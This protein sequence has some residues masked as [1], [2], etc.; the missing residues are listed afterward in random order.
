MNR[1]LLLLYV[2]IILFSWPAFASAQRWCNL[3]AMDLEKY[4]LT[5]YILTLSDGTEIHACSMHCAAIVLKKEDVK[6]VRVADYFTGKMLNAGEAFYVLGSDIGGVM[7]K[8]SKLAFATLN[9]AKKFREEH[10]GRVARFRAA[11]NQAGDDMAE[12]MKMI[13]ENLKRMALLGKLVAEKNSCFACHGEEGR[14][15]VINPGSTTG[16]VP[17]WDG[18][19]VTSRITSKALLKEVILTGTNPTMK[20][21]PQYL[22]NQKKERINM[23]SWRGFIQGRE[24]HALVN[25]IWSLGE[26]R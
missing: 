26:A 23:P 2:T 9:D 15:G 4:R 16:I 5:K 17:A 21:D 11:L 10:G 18:R 25:Y 6:K 24:L 22:S 7:S 12:D 20:E 3:C 8:K 14:G 1:Q 13:G 19:E